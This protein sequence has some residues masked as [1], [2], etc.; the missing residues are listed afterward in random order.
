MWRNPESPYRLVTLTT[1]ESL[2]AE[3]IAAAF[4]R[5][6]FAAPI[7]P[8]LAEHHDARIVAEALATNAKL[9]LTSNMRSINQTAANDW[10]KRWDDKLGFVP[11]RV[12]SDADATLV[13]WSTDPKREDRLLQAALMASWP[14]N[15]D[16]TARQIVPTAALVLNA[17][18]GEGGGRLPVTA[19]KLAARLTGH[20]NPE[21]LVSRTRLNLPSLRIETDRDH[22]RHPQRPAG[23]WQ[24]VRLATPGTKSWHP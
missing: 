11:Q 24:G 23:P 14:A 18:R 22:P 13:G 7:G 8:P 1:E 19:T 5:S 16:A 12:V 6:C 17:M 9:L 20:P 3:E 2:L 4:H 21:D 15:D 10:A